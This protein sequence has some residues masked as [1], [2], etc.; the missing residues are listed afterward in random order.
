LPLPALSPAPSSATRRF[1]DYLDREEQRKILEQLDEA[2]AAELRDKLDRGL[3]SRKS[4][5]DMNTEV[6]NNQVYRPK[7]EEGKPLPRI[8]DDWCS[9]SLMEAIRRE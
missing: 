7:P 8:Q 3:I 1:H 6:R 9:N 4:F 2:F 5:D